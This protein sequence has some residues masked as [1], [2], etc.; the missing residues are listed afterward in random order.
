[1]ELKEAFVRVFHVKSASQEIRSN[2]D[3]RKV[4][5]QIWRPNVGLVVVKYS[6]SVTGTGERENEWPSSQPNKDSN[7][8]DKLSYLRSKSPEKFT[9]AS[10]A[11][12][13][14][15][16]V[17]EQHKTA[18]LLEQPALPTDSLPAT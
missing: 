2:S 11:S 7:C 3:A 1:M 14:R 8:L 12:T 10:R 15:E 13:S 18:N 4:G 9:R 17:A 16:H 6:T 5:L